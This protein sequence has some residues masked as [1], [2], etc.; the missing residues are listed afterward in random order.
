MSAK[1]LQLAPRTQTSLP[2]IHRPLDALN[3]RIVDDL[4][5]LVAPDVMVLTIAA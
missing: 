4:Q 1:P 5:T 2:K 3:I